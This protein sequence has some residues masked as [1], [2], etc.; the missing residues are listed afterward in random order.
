[1]W[2]KVNR[3]LFKQRPMPHPSGMTCGLMDYEQNQHDAHISKSRLFQVAHSIRLSENC[4]LEKPYYKFKMK[5]LRTVQGIKNSK[6]VL[7]LKV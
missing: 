3:R 6:G 7:N 1:M 2:E 5:I 4:S